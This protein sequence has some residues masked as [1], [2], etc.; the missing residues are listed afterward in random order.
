MQTRRDHV[1]A[2]QFAMAQLG[3]AL[4]SGDPGRGYA[5]TRRPLLGTFFGFIIVV[6]LC[7][8]FAVYG[9]LVPGGNTSWR[10]AGSIIV[11]KETGNRYLYFDNELRPA[12]NY[13]SALLLAGNDAQVRSVS[14]NSL[15]GVRHGT[16]VG[17]PDAPDALPS[18]KDLLS[19]PWTRC[20]RD[21]VRSG[22][23]LGFD[24]GDRTRDFPDNRQVLLSS[25]KDDLYLLW[26]GTK[27]P[28]P[29][30]SALTALGLDAQLPVPAPRDWLSALPTGAR[31]TAAR[32]PRAGEPGRNVAGRPTVVGQLLRTTVADTDHYYVMRPDGVE[33]VSATQAALLIGRA[34]AAPARPVRSGD[35][36]AVPAAEADALTA[37]PDVLGVPLLRFDKEAL[38][39]LHTSRDTTLRTRVVLEDGPSASQDA[40]AVIPPGRGVLAVDQDQLSETTSPQLY[41]ITE[42]GVLHVLES[43]QSAGALGYASAVPLPLPEDVLKLLPQGPRLGEAAAAATVSGR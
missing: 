12:R 16:P 18:A 37:V 11:E 20:L 13:A 23:V 9:L 36:A 26:R 14:R 17:I 33:P 2:Y 1:Q 27:Y 6:L 29:D 40:R 41:L 7:I 24:P 35:V 38:C 43:D 19:G 42:Q 21:D 30:E 22:Q 8:A 5:P 34:G 31:L 15:A 39:L 3:S 28:I 32:I 4:V 25:G 10:K